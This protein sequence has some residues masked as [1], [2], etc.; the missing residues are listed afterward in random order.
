VPEGFYRVTRFNPTSSFHLALG[1]DY[2]NASRIASSARSL[3]AADIFIH[4]ACATIGCV[5]L[6]DEVI[7]ELY[8]IAWDTS[9]K[10]R[11]S[12]PILPQAH[13]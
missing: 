9:Q 10:G 5:P 11:P 13:G 2:P 8:L 12:T 6:T 3:S 7:E 4:G 1:V